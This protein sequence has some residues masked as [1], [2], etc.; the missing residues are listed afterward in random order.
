MSQVSQNQEVQENNSFESNGSRIHHHKLDRDFTILPNYSIED[1]RL[2]WASK[3]LLAYIIS[4]PDGWAIYTK[5]LATVY[6]GDKKGGGIEAIRS[7]VKEL[8]KYKYLVYTIGKNPDGTWAHR[9][10]CYPCPIDHFK[11]ISPERVY[12][13]LDSSSLANANIIVRRNEA[14]LNIAR[15]NPISNQSSSSYIA[16]EPPLSDV[17]ANDDASGGDDACGAD[18]KN[19]PPINPATDAQDLHYKKPNGVKAAITQAEIFRSFLSQRKPYS[20][21]CIREAIIRTRENP[22]VKGNIMKYLDSVCS[23]IHKKSQEP[24]KKSFKETKKEEVVNNPKPKKEEKMVT[25]ADK[26]R[27][28]AKEAGHKIED[29]PNKY[30]IAYQELLKNKGNIICSTSSISDQTLDQHI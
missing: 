29:H 7:C 19:D 16:L 18:K 21:D 23:Q 9:Y 12:P 3:G 20:T 24:I 26:E 4:K 13:N 17:D 22:N 15:K 10:D 1:P 25:W 2:T 11:K 8:I 6:T 27:Q 30:P 28:F 14:R 5:Q